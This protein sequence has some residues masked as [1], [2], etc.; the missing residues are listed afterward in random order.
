MGRI[1]GESAHITRLVDD[2]LLLARL[3]HHRGLDFERLDVVAVVREAATDFAG[4]APDRPLSEALDG[5]AVVLGDH[6]RLRQVVDNLLAN[7]RIH[8]PAGTPVR[9]ATRREG[10]QVAVTVA[11][12]GPGIPPA[13][14]P[15]VFER[16]W[17]A[18]P[19]RVRR[20]GG[21]GLGLAIVAS[22]M[23]A[24]GGTV[25]LDSAPGHGAAF[26]LRLPLAG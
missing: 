9:L 26:T 5:E 1:L 10:G 25:T 11:D 20:T 7:A 19:L 14:Q 4:V 12:E 24:H 6:H 3:D 8:T 23:Q 18:D 21:S 15:R 16:F 17:R 13:D 22:I 2:L